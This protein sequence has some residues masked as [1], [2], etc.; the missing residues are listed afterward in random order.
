MAAIRTLENLAIFNESLSY[1]I[2]HGK[3]MQE[4]LN[5]RLSSFTY[6][7]ITQ[8]LGALN[9]NIFKL[10]SV[11]FL[12]SISSIENSHFILSTTG[13]IFVIPFILFSSTSGM[14]ADRFSKRN[15]IVLTKILE[16]LVMTL[17]VLA[18]SYES[19][20]GTYLTL[21]LLATHSALFAPS[22]YGIVPEI[23]TNDQI[24]KANG[25][26]T[27]FTFLAIILGTFFASFIT[28]ITGRNFILASLLC[29]VISLAGVMT[30]FG[31]EYTL[32]SGSQ[33]KLNVHIFG[34]IL[35][36]LKSARNFTSLL[37]CILG[38]AFFL[39]IGAF[40]QLNI[41]PFAVESLHL[42]DVQGGYLFLL[43]A[44]GIGTGSLIAGKIS[45]KIV[46]LGLVPIG[47]FGITVGLFTLDFFSGNIAV[48]VPI[49]VI[50]GMFGGMYEIPL[51]AYIQVASPSNSRGQ[52][53]AATNFMSFV[54][55]LCA[56]VMV[57]VITEFLGLKADK[58][59][60]VLGV[61]TAIMT[62]IYGFLFFDYF[63]RFM[64]TIFCRLRFKATFEG[65][66]EIPAKPAIYVCRHTAW[67]DT[68]LMLG[69][70]R[71]R[72]RFFIEHE[73]HHTKW[74]KRFYRTLKVVLIPPIEPLEKNEQ[75]LA[76]IKRT[77]ESGIS[78]CIFADDIDL[79]AKIDK[80]LH[81]Y[82]FKEL[83]EN[84]DVPIL[85]VEILK[86]EKH[87]TTSRF[88]RWVNKLRVPALVSFNGKMAD[89]EAELT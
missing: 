69:A 73:Q 13:A 51:D 46:E 57:Y 80:L 44:L 58:G 60:T 1:I 43:T 27:S 84:N 62:V 61:L 86:G 87:K 5:K 67:N 71:R 8:F 55:V 40:M 70:Q 4:L 25:L 29:T 49:V 11:Y 53:V 3:M 79:E 38:S 47:I 22:K 75:C 2:I 77:L 54:G 28:E 33:K 7:N 85:Q 64:G 19:K 65:T 35:N 6:L 83:V 50:L 14:L 32:P 56:S 23:V 52:F 30:S 12:I 36:T 9:D 68:L 74:L 63:M 89:Q 41:I 20:I 26:M 31:I 37:A 78:V 45:G 81:S 66:S 21:F 24:S 48:V 82:S 15:I 72:M 17:G 18:F 34:E 88:F 16:L 39:F 42:S 10:L 76:Q 59:F